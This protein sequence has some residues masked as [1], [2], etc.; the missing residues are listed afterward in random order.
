MFTV[1][2]ECVFVYLSI[3]VHWY[4]GESPKAL[5]KASVSYFNRDYLKC[6][7]FQ[8][9][10]PKKRKMNKEIKRVHLNIIPPLRFNQC[11]ELLKSLK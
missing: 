1:V 3:C 5:F 4:V 2:Y 9:F 10:D 11:K 6:P 7:L 8:V